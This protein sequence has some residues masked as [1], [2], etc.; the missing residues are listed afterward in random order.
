MI[1]LNNIISEL[2][3]YPS[4]CLHLTDK[5]KKKAE[6]PKGYKICLKSYSQ[7]MVPPDDN[8]RPSISRLVTACDST[9]NKNIRGQTA[10]LPQ[11]SDLVKEA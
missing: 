7:G 4:H 5:K 11:V 8:T 6:A 1:S 2:D 10:K 9:L 3:R